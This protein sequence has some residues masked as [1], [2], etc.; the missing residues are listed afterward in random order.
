MY[1]E[2]CSKGV[3]G[4]YHVH[5]LGTH[6][7]NSFDTECRNHPACLLLA[8]SLNGQCHARRVLVTLYYY[9]SRKALAQPDIDL[10]MFDTC[11]WSHQFSPLPE[12]KVSK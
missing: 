9:N 4:T 2:R 11:R 1:P 7:A 8:E 6:I 5:S 10:C 3:S 12:V